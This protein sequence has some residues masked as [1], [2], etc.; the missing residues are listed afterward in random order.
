MS[1]FSALMELLKV[2]N[3]V[4]TSFH[5]FS[6]IVTYLSVENF[7]SC[8]VW[9]SLNYTFSKITIV[10][11]KSVPHAMFS[12][13]SQLFKDG[14]IVISIKASPCASNIETTYEL[15]LNN[16]CILWFMLCG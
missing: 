8:D 7:H 12:A 2:L 10:Q 11:Q 15:A 1:S 4:I 16:T 13:S 14:L 6:S 3:Q 5:Q 9:S